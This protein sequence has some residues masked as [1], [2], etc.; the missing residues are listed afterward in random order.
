MTPLISVI[1]PVFNGKRFLAAAI[2]N[3]IGQGTER[4]EHII[5]DGG[6]TDGSIDTLRDYASRYP[7]IG[8][9]SEKD[10]GQSDAMNKGIKMASGEFISFLNADDFYQPGVIQ[11]VLGLIEQTPPAKRQLLF[12][13][14]NTRVS[15]DRDELIWFNRPRLH[16]AW[17]L[18]GMNFRQYPVNPSAYF[19]NKS[20]HERVG[21]YSERNE[22][23]S[24][25]D[26]EF[27]LRAIPVMEL[28]YIN[29]H[30]GN[31]RQ[32]A[33]T[34]TTDI[35]ATGEAEAKV[36]MTLR[37]FHSSLPWS[38]RWWVVPMYHFANSYAYRLFLGFLYRLKFIISTP[39]KAAK[40]AWEII[41][42]TGRPFGEH[43]TY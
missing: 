25:M 13:L 32:Y 34:V 11:R 23:R 4:I 40:R 27:V 16:R 3:V 38:Q 28:R 31:F 2:E 9:M 26:L 30:W 19:Y 41:T 33:G 5:V 14:G 22:H 39:R 36:M 29:E 42:R 1:T 8:W 18:T 35:Y 15:N 17:M 10:R 21:L 20:L 24:H 6:S 37:S 43:Q 7:H 12:L